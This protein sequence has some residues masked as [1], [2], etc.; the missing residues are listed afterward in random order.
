MCQEKHPLN[1][2]KT[3]FRVNPLGLKWHFPPNYQSLDKQRFGKTEVW[4]NR[5]CRYFFFSAYFF[6]KTTFFI[7]FTSSLANKESI[8]MFGIKIGPQIKAGLMRKNKDTLRFITWI[9]SFSKKKFEP[10]FLKKVFFLKK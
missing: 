7:F 2:R 1:F 5:D 9:S 10:L 3:H 8:L 6:L 4:T